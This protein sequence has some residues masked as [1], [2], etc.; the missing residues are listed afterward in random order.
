MGLAQPCRL[1][2]TAERAP[3]PGC[4]TGAH[5]IMKWHHQGEG[6][7]L[8]AGRTAAAGMRTIAAR[9]YPAGMPRRDQALHHGQV[10]SPP[11]ACKQAAGGIWPS[12]RTGR[13]AAKSPGTFARSRTAR[14][15]R[16]FP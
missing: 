5:A 1:E 9:R 11:A 15:S 3:A 12:P 16:T 2:L 4:P 8:W 7:K 10:L 14:S 6:S 13:C